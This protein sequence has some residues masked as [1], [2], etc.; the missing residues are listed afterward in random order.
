M[1]VPRDMDG[2]KEVSEHAVEVNE[3]R[4]GPETEI[5]HGSSALS[6]IHLLPPSSSSRD[7]NQLH[8]GRNTPHP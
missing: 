6:V 5:P 7:L 4:P 3:G 2:Y 8:L 1:M